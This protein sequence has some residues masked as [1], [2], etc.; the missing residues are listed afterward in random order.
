LRE[1]IRRVLEEQSFSAAARR[2]RAD[3]EALPAAS[4]APAVLEKFLDAGPTHN[5]LAGC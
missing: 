3:F 4:E 1:A 5:R 2:V